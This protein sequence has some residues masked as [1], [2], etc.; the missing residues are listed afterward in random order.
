MNGF[1]YARE[2]TEKSLVELGHTVNFADSTADIEI[3]FI[4]PQHWVW[5]GVKYRIAYLPWESTELQPGWLE[6]LNSDVD[7]VWTPSPIVADWFRDAGVNKPVHVFE[8]GVEP[9]WRNKLRQGHIP[10]QVFH[11]GADAQRK[12]F[13]ETIEGF[14][15]VFKPLGAQMN[16]K[17]A[18]NG[19]NVNIP[20][21]NIIRE[22]LPVQELVELY[23]AQDLMVY[24]SWG[25]GFGLAPLQSIATGMPTIITKGWSPYEH[26]MFEEELVETELVDSPWQMIHPGKMFRP[27]QESLIERMKWIA[28]EDN[29]R[30]ISDARFAAADGVHNEYSW[31]EKTRIAFEHLI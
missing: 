5:S 18:M 22:R 26:L 7:E 11:H 31:V 30:F 6:K 27:V 10:S 8:H 14:N 17:M 21:V 15:E 12:G 9:L 16:F 19:F 4:Q 13:R 2:M 24:P 28:E 1:G 20:G 23:H 3:N 25:E 29:Y